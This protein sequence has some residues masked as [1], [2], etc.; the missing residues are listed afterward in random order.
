MKDETEAMLDLVPF[1]SGRNIYAHH[2]WAD[3]IIPEIGMFLEKAAKPGRS[4]RVHLD[5]HTSVAM[6]V[7]FL[8]DTKAG[9]DISPMQKTIHGK[10]IWSPTS[11]Q[12]GLPNPGWT[13]TDTGWRESQ[14]L[15]Q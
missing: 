15:V 14:L 4:Y 11:N 10:A 2:L 6:V 13:Y 9:V 3:S 1:F 8:L 7:G 5:T 12:S